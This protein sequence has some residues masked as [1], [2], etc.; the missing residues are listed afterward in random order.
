MA[1]VIADEQS[2]RNRLVVQ[3]FRHQPQDFD[4][5]LRESDAPLSSP[6]MR[7]IGCGRLE[8]VENGASPSD[9]QFRLEL[10]Q[11][12]DR[13]LSLF[14][15]GF[16]PVERREHAGQFDSRPRYLEWRAT[17]EKKVHRVFEMLPSLV[18]VADASGD[19]SLGKAGRPA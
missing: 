4:L 1:G 9:F 7:P 18:R 12:I 19:V 2:L 3:S 6:A 14:R 17:F 10:Q 15:S 5:A 13:S 16:D 8:R 11:Q